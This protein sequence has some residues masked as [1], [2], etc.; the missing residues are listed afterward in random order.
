MDSCR[1]NRFRPGREQTYRGQTVPMGVRG[2]EGITDGRQARIVYQRRVPVVIYMSKVTIIGVTGNV[3]QFAAYAISEISYLDQLVLFGREGN[4]EILEGILCDF[5]DS[6][7]ARGRVLELIS[8]TY[9]GDIRGSDIVVITSGVPREDGQDRIDLAIDNAKVVKYYAEMVGRI[10]PESIIL[11]VTNPV[12]I[13]TAV[14][15]KYS[16]MKPNQVFGLGT[17]LDSMRLKS[18]IAR[19]FNVHVSEVH[20]RIIGEH[21]ASMVPLWSATTVG[22]IQIRNLPTFSK[23]PLEFMVESVKTAGAHI[24]KKIGATIYGPGEAISTIVSTI[25]GNEN[26]ILTV[27]SYI[28]SEVHDVGDVCIGVPAR[29]NNN[30]SFPVAIRI[31]ESELIAFSES[32]EKIRTI[33]NEVIAQLEEEE[34]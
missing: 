24:I 4:E 19:H 10:A 33:T 30:G 13:M 29:I 14:A 20:T 5:N 34:Q 8:S 7:A 16:G 25:L 28:K 26:R 27:S 11:M 32:V 2:G 1:G 18:F 17:H 22:G 6:F 3:G 12:D 9:P 31:E 21:G 23:L 15:L